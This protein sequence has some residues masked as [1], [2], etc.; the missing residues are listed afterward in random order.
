MLASDLN[1]PEFTGVIQNPDALLHVQ[2]YWHEP[3]D[4]WESEKIGRQVKGPKVPF[5]RF[6]RPGDPLS[7]MEIAVDESHK[8]RWPQM[9]MAWQMQE[10]LIDGQGDIPGWKLEE[11]SD[12][13]EEQRHELKYL[14]FS[15]VEQIAGASDTQVQRMGMGGLA[16]RERAKHAL[17]NKMGAEVKAEIE[18][19]D[20]EIAELKAQMREV[21][22]AVRPVSIQPQPPATNEHVAAGAE[23]FPADV[24]RAELAKQYEEKFGKKPHHKMAAAT[25]KA[26]LAE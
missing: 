12:L 10:G 4:K 15:T 13:T 5:V 26:K 8:R 2:F 23:P 11:W 6:M 16:L 14:R 18:S 22:A 25:I 9:W 1:N 7:V 17:R 21:L 20:R 24:E 3:I 19:R